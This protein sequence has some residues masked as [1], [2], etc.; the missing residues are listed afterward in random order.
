LI[1]GA[2]YRL[3]GLTRRVLPERDS[4]I[5]A[6]KWDKTTEYLTPP[7]KP[8]PVPEPK[9]RLACGREFLPY[10]HDNQVFCHVVD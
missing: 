2:A 4:L 7:E 3:A 1:G 8:E 5:F 10:I 9:V 6:I